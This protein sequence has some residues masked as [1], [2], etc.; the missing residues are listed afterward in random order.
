VELVIAR[1][2]DEGSKLPYLL[3]LP[4]DGGLVLKARETWPGATRVY[5]HECR[6]AGP[7]TPKCSS[8]SRCARAGAAARRWTCCSRAD[9][10]TAA[11]S[12]SPS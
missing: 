10:T 11:S 6:R 3:R 5:C 7:T 4:I 9:A 8:A 1:N 12:C 2:P